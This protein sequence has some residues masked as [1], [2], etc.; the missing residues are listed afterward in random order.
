MKKKPSVFVLDVDGV[1][2]D[3]KF[4]YSSSGKILECVGADDNDTLKIFKQDQ[5]RHIITGD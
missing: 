3:G 2:T 4:Y 5:D 1:L